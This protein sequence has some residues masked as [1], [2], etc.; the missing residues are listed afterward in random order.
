MKRALLLTLAALIWA[1]ATLAQDD[2]L[3]DLK[4]EDA[5][6]VKENIAAA[7]FKSTRIINMHSVEMTGAGNLQFMIIH[8]FGPLWENTNQPGGDLGHNMG[9][10]FGMNGN[11]ANIYMAFDYAPIRWANLGFAFAGQGNLEGTAKFKLLRQQTGKRNIPVSV[12]FL[13]VAN[14]NTSKNVESPN[15]LYWNRFTYMQQ[16]LV[17]RKFNENFSVQVNGAMIHRNI[18]AY[19]FENQHNTWSAGIGL[20]Y[21]L[22][23][24]RAI[25]FEYNRQ[26][27]MYENVIDKGGNVVNYS[28][29]LFSFGYDWD[30]GG[31]IFQFF[32]SNSGYASNLLQLSQNPVKDGFGQWCLGFNL[33]RSYTIKHTVKTMK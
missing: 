22:T 30:T 1:G 13:S 2:L 20:R 31:H 7:T 17:A 18:I 27:N 3:N 21:K 19:G 33:N 32:F 23:A 14:F 11:L 16:L 12:A 28:P 5:A 8:H 25:S 10:F 15:G 29:N 26:L 9:R 4:S 6:K 24:K